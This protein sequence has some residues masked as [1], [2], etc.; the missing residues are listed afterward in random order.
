MRMK[1]II[2]LSFAVIWPAVVAAQEQA[3]TDAVTDNGRY[4]TTVWEFGVVRPGTELR[5]T[6]AIKND[7]E[8]PWTVKYVSKSCACTVGEFSSKS[9]KP[10]EMLSVEVTF[11][12]EKEG[13]VHQSIVV[14]LKER[15]APVLC[16]VMKGESRRPLSADPAMVDFG[17]VSSIDR[18]TRT[19]ELRNYS[20]QDVSITRVEAPAWLKVEHRPIPNTSD[21]KQPRQAWNLVVA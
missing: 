12:V 1:L 11:R 3:G 8:I 5:H 20:D 2:T 21:K 14:D 7:T 13:T 16:F 19:V 10:L 4:R 9:V 6:F 17:P 15:K 18:V